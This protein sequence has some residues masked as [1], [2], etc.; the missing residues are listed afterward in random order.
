MYASATTTTTSTPST[1]TTT[2]NNNINNNDNDNNHN[3]HHNN[4]QNDSPA[5]FST[6]EVIAVAN[7]S[8]SH[9]STVGG[10]SLAVAVPHAYLQATGAMQ[11]AVSRLRH[12]S[13][14][15][16]FKLAYHKC[17]HVVWR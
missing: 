10:Q 14:F 6:A 15:F 16:F 5:C 17:E 3:H 13:V 4:D 12:V 2:N 1:T 11:F 9:G 7:A 8:V